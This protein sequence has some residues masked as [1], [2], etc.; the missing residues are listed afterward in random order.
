MDDKN[1]NTVN[2]KNINRLY[3]NLTYFDQYSSSIL[4]LIILFIVLVI[5]IIYCHILMNIKPI[6]D[7]WLNQR[8]KPF[9]I[10]FAGLINAPP[11]ISA[12]D[13]TKQNF[14]YCTQS[15]LKN[16]TGY[17]VQPLTYSTQI[18]FN[19]FNDIK[20]GI[21]SSREMFDKVRNLFSGVTQEIMGRIYNIIT[22]LQQII[23]AFRD[24]IGK[25]MGIMTTGLFTLLASYYSLK[26]LLGAIA[27]MVVSILIALVALIALLWIFPFTWGAAL[28]FTAMFVAIS[29]PLAIMLAFMV[30]VMKIQPGLSIPTLQVHS[31]KCF[32]KNTQLKMAD[33]SE[34]KIIDIQ[35]GEL[36]QNN[37]VVT[38]KFK[39]ETKGSQMYK[40]YNII[41][42]DSHMIKYGKNWIRINEHP[43]SIKIDNYDEQY[44]Y[45]LNTSNKTIEIQNILFSDWDEIIEDDI[46]TFKSYYNSIQKLYN[47]EDNCKILKN[48][49]FNES[50]IHKYFDC[51][52]YS[53]TL[54]K[55]K[56]GTQKKICEIEI[57]DI[58]YNNEKVYGTVEIDG[59]NLVNQYSYNLDLNDDNSIIIGG[60]NINF[61]DTK[62]NFTSSIKCKNKS[63]LRD[64]IQDK[65]YYLLTSK[66]SFY[67]GK[68]KL[69]DYNACVDIILDK[70][71]GK[72][73]SMK[74]V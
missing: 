74:Y 42:S 19:M 31:V 41:V 46:Y 72:L 51:G 66:K 64:N 73:L 35:I 21:N 40:L 9:I 7:D 26:A 65:L 2:L 61:C 53:N 5:I 47:T 25:V 13:Y 16:T 49:N 20:E 1:D 37:N 17:A 55:L 12:N 14:N 22:P 4:L 33:G 54:I 60:P 52:L 39:V 62:L 11:G 57:G 71:R 43:D 50:H 8:C 59:T 30:D 38:A 6:Q 69:F 56:D 32:D 45:C 18:L 48:K 36:L 23:I 44:L 24:M 58:L 70:N 28:S 68:F 10:P 34:K 63:I 29:I 3:E 15:I 67:V 27:Q